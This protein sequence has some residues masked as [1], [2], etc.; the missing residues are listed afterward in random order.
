MMFFKRAEF[1]RYARW[2]SEGS[3]HEFFSFEMMSE[4][5]IPLPPIHV[6]EAIVNVYK[7]LEEAR[8][9]SIELQKMAAT[10]CPALIQRVSH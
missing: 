4:V 6:Q 2:R 5:R 3:A 8:I 9:R 7:G 10:I 1:D